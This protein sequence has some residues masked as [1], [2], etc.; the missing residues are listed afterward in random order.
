MA[1]CWT[2][3]LFS[4]IPLL[5]SYINLRSLFGL[6]SGDILLSLGILYHAHLQLFQK[7]F[8]S[9]VFEIFVILLVILLPIKSH[10]ASAVFFYYSFWTSFKCIC[11][12]LFSNIKKFLAVFTTQVFTYTFN[13]LNVVKNMKF[14]GDISSIWRLVINDLLE[15]NVYKTL[16]S[17][18]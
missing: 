2:N 18:P 9:E 10:V 11:C 8:C 6:S 4:D 14:L 13:E 7:K 16:E 12:R 1:Y 17:S 5:Y 3:L 15:I